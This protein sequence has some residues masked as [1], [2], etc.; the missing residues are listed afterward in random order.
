MKKLLT[1]L[2]IVAFAG[3]AMAA[4]STASSK[5][6]SWLNKTRPLVNSLGRIDYYV[7]H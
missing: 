2:T 3:T 4:T 6:S 1:V 5:V 7:K